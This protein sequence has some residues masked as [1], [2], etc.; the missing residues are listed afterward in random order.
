MKVVTL[1]GGEPFM[2]P[3][4]DKIARRLTDKGVTAN[5]ISNGW[6]INQELVVKAKAA[7]IVNIGVSLDGL[8]QTHEFIRMPGAFDHVLNALDIM[9]EN[10]MPT[11]VC[12]SV[13][14]LNF[15][16]LPELKKLL[17]EKKVQRWQFQ[18]ASPMGNLLDNPELICAMDEADKLIDFTYEV[19]QENKI[20]V[21]LAD[22]IGYFNIKE[23]EIRKQSFNVER[24]L[25]IWSGCQAGK[26]VMGIRANGDISGCLSI[27][28]SNFIE[29]VR[30][31]L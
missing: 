31:R 28:D 6:F 10:A 27:R 11:V 19:M 29:P 3:L 22:D 20:I 8:K 14:K 24:P 2:H 25:T 9:N 17:Y 23:N 12:T 4:W 16:E 30:K 5:V 13:N 1:S 7:G 26:C 15:P 21:D 18:I